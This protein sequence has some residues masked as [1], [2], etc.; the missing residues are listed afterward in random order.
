MT[1]GGRMIPCRDALE[2]IYEFMDGELEGASE[3]EVEEHF[4]VCTRCYPHLHLEQSF[5][6]RVR[7]ALGRPEV[8]EHLRARVL[9]MLARED[10]ST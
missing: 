6:D 8:P 3:A 2:R 9:E 7:D 1:E 4:R 5:R 10:R